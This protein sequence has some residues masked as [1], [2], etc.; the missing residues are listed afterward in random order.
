MNTDNLYLSGWR[1]IEKLPGFHKQ[2]IF[3]PNS[4]F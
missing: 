3:T 4:N 1:W 2:R